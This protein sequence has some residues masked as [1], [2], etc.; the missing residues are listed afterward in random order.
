MKN[1]AIQDLE[2]EEKKI[3]AE[4]KSKCDSNRT[5][6]KQGKLILFLS[7][8]V[9][10]FFLIIVFLFVY[11]FLIK[12]EKI[13][14]NAQESTSNQENNHIEASYYAMAGKEM[15]LINP[16]DIG[17]KDEDYSIEEIEFISKE[18]SN[19][20]Y[21]KFLNTN[22]GKF[23]PSS[24]GILT[25]KIIFK[26]KLNSLDGLF[27]NN[28]ELIKV[29][30]GKFNMEEV[31]SMKSTFSGCSNLEY[32]NL[33]KAD[34]RENCL[35]NNIFYNVPH[36]IVYCINNYKLSNCLGWKVC[37]SFDCTENCHQKQKKIFP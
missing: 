37:G 10:L 12:K 11:F 30:L 16:D 1:N 17:L 22:N 9:L 4:S 21:L 15:K 2:S 23:L 7:I 36:N 34:V 13:I 18:S 5:P 35:L 24:T 31:T 25:T 20:R 28:K 33:I 32:I 26:N 19:L 8:S 14:S 27:K 3:K 6:Q 29:N